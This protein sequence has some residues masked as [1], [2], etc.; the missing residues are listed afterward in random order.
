MRTLSS[1]ASAASAICD[2]V[3]AWLRAAPFWRWRSS[4]TSMG[5]MSDGSYNVPPGI[6]FSFP[7]RCGDGDWRI[8]KVGL[9]FLAQP[10]HLKRSLFSGQAGWARLR[11]N[12]ARKPAMLGMSGGTI[13]FRS[14]DCILPAGCISEQPMSS[15]QAAPAMQ[16]TICRPIHPPTC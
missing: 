13:F 6:F 16:A 7:V 5:V 3:H 15:R 9:G 12:Y 2:H 10:P 1:A 8:E 14:M 4:V 11:A